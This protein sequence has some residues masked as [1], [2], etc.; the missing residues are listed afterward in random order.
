V[1]RATFHAGSG[2]PAPGY[3]AVV[4]EVLCFGWLDG[5]P[6]KREARRTMLRFAPRLPDSAW[7][8]PNGQRAVRLLAKDRMAS[9]AWPRCR[10]RRPTA[11]GRG[12]GLWPAE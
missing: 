7:G 10:R 12:A 6:R 5:R 2:E 8:R 9:P 11:A 1:W 3:D 4:E